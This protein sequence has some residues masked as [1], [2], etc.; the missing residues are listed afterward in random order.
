[1][2]VS[3]KNYKVIFKL[4]KNAFSRFSDSDALTHAAALSYYTLFSLP[5]LLLITINIAGLFYDQSVVDKIIFENIAQF[6]GPESALELSK[7]VKNLSLSPDSNIMAIIGVGALVFSSTTVFVSIQNALNQLFQVTFEVEGW[8]IKKVIK[9]RLISFSLIIGFAFLIMITLLAQTA[10]SVFLNYAVGF[11]PNISAVL[12]S[13]FTFLISLGVSVGLLVLIFKFLPDRN[14]RWRNTFLGAF[15]T[16]LLIE[17][18]KYGIS[19][20]LS[21]STMVDLYSSAGNVL[22]LILWVYYA[23][24]IFL[25]GGAF[26]A[27]YSE[28][29]NRKS[30][31]E[32]KKA[33]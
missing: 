15:I 8:G 11:L 12:A 27:V 17:L 3:I 18:G 6:I 32:I 31:F 9:D 23:S 24:A 16:A 7:T 22:V 25:F 10:I 30:V 5:P 33:S 19:F 29:R 4:L 1:M 26:I 21:N 14:L 2:K 13:V 20:Y 28:Y